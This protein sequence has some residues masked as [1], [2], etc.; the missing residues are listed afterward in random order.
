M[1]KFGIIIFM[2][3]SQNFGHNLQRFKLGRRAKAKGY[4]FV[5][6]DK[7]KF[8]LILGQYQLATWA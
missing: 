1:S 3:T 4:N 7:P 5:V 6:Y 8:S 2:H